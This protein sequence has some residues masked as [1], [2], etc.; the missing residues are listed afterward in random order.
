VLCLQWYYYL[1]MVE[2]LILRFTWTITMS[3]TE[4]GFI[5]SEILRTVMAVLEVIR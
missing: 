3:A 2:D 5:D 1:A 4:T